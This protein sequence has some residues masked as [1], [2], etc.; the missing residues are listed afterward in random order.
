[1]KKKIQWGKIRRIQPM[2]RLFDRWMPQALT[3]LGLLKFLQFLRMLGVKAKAG[4]WRKITSIFLRGESSRFI[5]GSFR[6]LPDAMALFPAPDFNTASIRVA[7]KL[8]SFLRLTDDIGYWVEP[9]KLAFIRRRR[10]FRDL[11]LLE[12]DSLGMIVKVTP[13]F[14]GAGRELEKGNPLLNDI[15]STIQYHCNNLRNMP[16]QVRAIVLQKKMQQWGKHQSRFYYFGRRRRNYLVQRI[17][18]ATVIFCEQMEATAPDDLTRERFMMPDFRKYR[19]P[20]FGMLG[21]LARFTRDLK[22]VDLWCQFNHVAADGLPMQEFLNRLKKDWGSAGETVYPKVGSEGGNSVQLRYTG[23]GNFRALF[24]AD[25]SPLLE[26]RDYLNN[27]YAAE[28]GGKASIAGLIMWGVTRHE[29]FYRKKFLLPV[30]AGL[31]N[32]ER[33]LGF[34]IIRPR[35][36]T[37]GRGDALSDFCN[38]QKEMNKRLKQARSGSGAVSEFMELCAL[39]HPLF[40]HAAKKVWPRALNEVLGTVGLSILRD[41]EMFLSPMTEFQ[42]G[43]FITVG[44]VSVKTPD[45]STAA[46]VSIAGKRK[47]IRYALEALKKLPDDLVGMLD[48]QKKI[49]F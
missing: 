4:G 18:H 27:Y 14:D 41:S 43:G 48:L 30:D 17:L 37:G 19:N 20:G 3:M 34:L 2:H 22:E 7:A 13:F 47:Q 28:M 46:A 16:E 38:F 8:A 23:E 36:F 10:R 25:F 21:V 9:G 40:Y 15:I 45:G 26:V 35:Q 44:N 11:L 49:R 24:F 12:V 5:L 32:G 29:A 31:F 42:S 1:M 6:L 33:E 39:M